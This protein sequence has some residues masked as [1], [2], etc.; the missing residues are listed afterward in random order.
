[1]SLGLQGIGNGI[2]HLLA[3]CMGGRAAGLPVGRHEWAGVP[4]GASREAG[5]VMASPSAAEWEENATPDGGIRTQRLRYVPGGALKIRGSWDTGLLLRDD[6][7][8]QS[9]L[10]P[11]VRADAPTTRSS[12]TA[13][14]GS[15]EEIIGLTPAVPA[16]GLGVAVISSDRMPP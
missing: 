15:S 14:A 1:M 4:A 11:G 16:A 6:G 7:S 13:E 10:F 9:S 2:G 8:V 5:E 3:E 12:A